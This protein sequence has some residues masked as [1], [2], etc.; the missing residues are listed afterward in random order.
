MNS[1]TSLATIGFYDIFT[2][3]FS[4]VDNAHQKEVTDMVH[5]KIGGNIYFL[6]SSID[7]SIKAWR[8]N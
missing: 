7:G 3:Q 8:P 6:S 5:K 2:K 4:L 1:N